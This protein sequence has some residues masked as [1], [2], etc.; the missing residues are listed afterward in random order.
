MCLKI[1]QVKY[2]VNINVGY[3]NYKSQASANE[4]ELYDRSPSE[5]QTMSRNM[6]KIHHSAQFRD[7]SLGILWY[8]IESKNSGI[9]HPYFKPLSTLLFQKIMRKK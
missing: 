7:I 3:R 8:R 9:A 1:Y 2:V 5:R 6:V 4:T